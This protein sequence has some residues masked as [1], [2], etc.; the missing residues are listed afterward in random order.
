MHG[1]WSRRLEMTTS[2]YLSWLVSVSTSRGSFS[3]KAVA[4]SLPQ[5]GLYGYFDTYAPLLQRWAWAC[6]FRESVPAA[7]ERRAE[8]ENCTCCYSDWCMDPWGA[9]VWAVCV[10]PLEQPMLCDMAVC[11]MVCCHHLKS[12]PQKKK[13]FHKAVQCATCLQIMQASS[14]RIVL[15]CM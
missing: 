14:H 1:A 9:M 3:V 15:F 12:P 7:F 4:R 6:D 11:W 5:S 10:Q 13:T 2:V 8:V